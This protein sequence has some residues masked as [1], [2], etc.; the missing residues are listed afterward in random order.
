MASGYTHCACRDC[1]DVTASW[2]M[3]KATLCT[4]CEEAECEPLP[5]LPFPGMLSM[6]EC[7]R[8]DAY[9]G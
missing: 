3:S 2:D 9:T 4:E 1:F 8:D 6:F 7:Q 5:M